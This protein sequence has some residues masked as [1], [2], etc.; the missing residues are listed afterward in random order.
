MRVR[1]DAR[2]KR[3]FRIVLESDLPDGNETSSILPSITGIPANDA[4]ADGMM[5][6]GPIS[7]IL[8]SRTE[9]TLPDRIKTSSVLPSDLIISAVYR[10]AD[11]RTESAP[12]FFR[13]W[14]RGI[15]QSCRGGI[16]TWGRT[17]PP[18]ATVSATRISAIH[19]GWGRMAE[20]TS[21]FSRSCMPG[22]VAAGRGT[23]K[24][25]ATSYLISFRLVARRSGMGPLFV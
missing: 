6:S 10:S 14:C 11:G 16:A 12:N 9:G 20:F 18:S 8:R 23:D 24:S 21:I 19:A 7:A 25:A 3:D 17:N 5:E 1:A 4:G 13:S 22:A 15:F 2:I